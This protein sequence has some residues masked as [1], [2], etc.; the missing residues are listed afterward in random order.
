M[1]FSFKYFFTFTEEIL[2]GKH[3]VVLVFENCFMYKRSMMSV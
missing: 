3:L 1:K 2:K